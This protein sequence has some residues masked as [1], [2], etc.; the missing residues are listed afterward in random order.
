MSSMSLQLC[1]GTDKWQVYSDAPDVF[2]IP[3]NA[4]SCGSHFY[5]EAERLWRAE[6]GT[7][8]LA[9][10]QSLVIMCHV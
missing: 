4:D 3:G 1:F 6:E 7:I 8:S 9:N 10:I 2:A 5:I